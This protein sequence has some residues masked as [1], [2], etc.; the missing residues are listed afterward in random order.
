MTHSVSVLALCAAGLRKLAGQVAV[1]AI[2]TICATVVYGHFVSQRGPSEVQRDAGSI[3]SRV[4]GGV[5]DTRTLAYYPEHLATLDSLSHFRP[6]STQRTAELAAELGATRSAAWL[7][8]PAKRQHVAQSIVAPP[9]PAA[10]LPVNV[11]P[12]RRPA[13]APAPAAVAELAPEPPARAKVLGLELPRFVPTGAVV[14]D[15]LASVKNR[16]GD[17]IHVSSR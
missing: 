10:V 4:D 14:I 9:H 3:P 17:L 1:S 11:L 15:K 8:D 16:I 2:A 12:P 6:V 5:V 13:A 7:P